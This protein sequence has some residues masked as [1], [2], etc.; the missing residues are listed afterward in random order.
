MRKFILFLIRRKL[1]VR[2]WQRFQFANQKTSAEYYFG[3]NV[4]WKE[5]NG[6]LEKSH[7]SLNWLLDPECEICKV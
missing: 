5:W 1:H 3:E 4:I 6:K 2:K 7:V